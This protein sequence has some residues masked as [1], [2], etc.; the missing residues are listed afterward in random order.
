MKFEGT[1]QLTIKGLVEGG[2]AYYESY[3]VGTL[4]KQAKYLLD[5][6]GKELT[7]FR[8]EGMRRGSLFAKFPR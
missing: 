5:L 6:E 4:S 7:H 2:E 8:M 1:D 3:L